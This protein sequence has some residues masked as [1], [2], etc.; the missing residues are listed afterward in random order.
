MVEKLKKFW[1]K[2][3]EIWKKV[4]AFK[5]TKYIVV[6]GIAAIV[7]II[8]IVNSNAI[9]VQKGNKSRRVSVNIFDM[10]IKKIY[11]IMH[12]RFQIMA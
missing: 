6:L 7:F 9:F 2:V 10:N 3:V 1:E 12:D 4:V 11:T 8:V 5:G